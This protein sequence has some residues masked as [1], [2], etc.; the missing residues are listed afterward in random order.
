M[1]N[2]D[3]TSFF[4]ESDGGLNTLLGEVVEADMIDQFKRLLDRHRQVQAIERD[5][6][7]N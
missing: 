7:A 4:T 6:Q 5:G 2:G 3:G 1:F